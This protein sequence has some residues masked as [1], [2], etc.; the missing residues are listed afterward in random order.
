M[1][2]WARRIRTMSF[3]SKQTDWTLGELVAAKSGANGCEG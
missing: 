3:V 2:E 1:R